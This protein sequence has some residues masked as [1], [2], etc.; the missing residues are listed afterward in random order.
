[1]GLTGPLPGGG[2]QCFPTVKDN[3]CILRQY[4]S[5]RETP[6][7]NI[8]LHTKHYMFPQLRLYRQNSDMSVAR[9]TGMAQ[10]LVPSVVLLQ[11]LTNGTSRLQ[12]VTL[13]TTARIVQAWREQI[14]RYLVTT[15]ISHVLQAWCSWNKKTRFKALLTKTPERPGYRRGQ[16][17]GQKIG[18]LQGFC[19]I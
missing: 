11:V 2:S 6:A 13:T 19:W 9:S 5:G 18:F 8:A 1:M 7:Q 4:I 14:L 12:N 15:P 17:V 16:L 3:T 10:A